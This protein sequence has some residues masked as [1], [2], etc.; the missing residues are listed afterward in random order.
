[1]LAPAGSMVS[2]VIGG[3]VSVLGSVAAALVVVVLAVYLLN[4]FDRITAG[5]HALL[6]RR[7]QAIVTSY[8]ADIDGMLSHSLNLSAF[9]DG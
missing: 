8:A 4:D 5:V 6:P 1:M 9:V 3:T 2:A 7:W